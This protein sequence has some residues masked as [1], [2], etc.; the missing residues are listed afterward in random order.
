MRIAAFFL[1]HMYL[2]YMRFVWM[3][4]KIEDGTDPLLDDALKYHPHKSVSLMWHQDVFMVAWAYRRFYGTTIASKG[5]FGDIISKMLAKCNYTTFRGGTS[6]GK[7]RGVKVLDEFIE[8]LE[9]QD[10]FAVGITVDGSSGPAYRVKTG[11]IVMAMKTGVPVFVTRIWAKRRILMPTWDRTM[12]PLPFN[13][14]VINFQGPFLPPENLEDKEVFDKFHQNMENN[15]LDATYDTFL[16][17]DGKSD[18]KSIEKFPDYWKDNN[19][20][21]T[22]ENNK[23]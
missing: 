6:K 14:I 19:K 8:H 3:T 7:K 16:K 1:P 15:L 18:P 2:L 13:R 22:Q 5:D 20:D 12:I 23:N 10:H 9:K 4:S 11:T 21:K 17:V